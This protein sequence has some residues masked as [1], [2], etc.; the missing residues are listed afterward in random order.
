MKYDMT[1]DFVLLFIRRTEFVNFLDRLLS[2]CVSF[3]T[4][5]LP[6]FGTIRANCTAHSVPI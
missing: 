4:D 1:D 2:A 6:Y 5:L 3:S